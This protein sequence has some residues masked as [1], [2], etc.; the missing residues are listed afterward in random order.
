MS[1]RIYF[2]ESQIEKIT[3]EVITVDT[4]DGND[5]VQVDGCS[6]GATVSQAKILQ[7]LY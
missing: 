4:K 2:D 6:P 7:Y 3:D 1:G 5:T